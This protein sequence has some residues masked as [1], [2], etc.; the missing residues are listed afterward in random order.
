MKLVEGLQGL[1]E[2]HHATAG[3]VTLAW[4]L[5]QG[6]DIIP[7]PG[8]KRIKVQSPSI[9]SCSLLKAPMLNTLAF[10]ISKKI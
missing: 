9:S 7:I 4:L 8:T 10:S 2:K 6:D 5:A 3:Q 1:G